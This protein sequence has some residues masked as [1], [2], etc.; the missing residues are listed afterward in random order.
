MSVRAR[1]SGRSCRERV[2]PVGGAPRAPR[3]GGLPPRSRARAICRR[4]L[5]AVFAAALAVL[6]AGT[7]LADPADGEL[8]LQGGDALG[9]GRV[10]VYHDGAWGAVCD[11]FW[12]IADARVV[13]RQLGY[14]GATTALRELSGPTDI[15]MW[16]DNMNC[17]GSEARLADCDGAGWGPHNPHHCSTVGEHAGVACTLS[18]SSAAVLIA[19][20]PVVVDEHTSATYEV[21]LTKLPSG[22]VTVAIGGTTG[23][24]VS[25]DKTSLTFTT[26]DWDEPQTVTVTAADDSDTA[27][28]TV[29]LTH[30]PTGGG[31]GSVSVPNLTVRVEDNDI[32][33]AKVEPDRVTIDEGDTEGDTAGDSYSFELT[34]E[35]TGTVT[36]TV[37]GTAGTDVTA[38]PATLTFTTSD[39]STAQTVTVTA[40]NDSDEEDDRVSLTH[41]AA[42]GGYGS[43]ALPGVTVLVRDRGPDVKVS[44]DRIGI[45]EGDTPGGTYTVVLTRRPTGPVT[46]TLGGTAG[47][48]VTV[49]PASLT[50]TTSD[51]ETA[52]TVS[53]SAAEDDDSDSDAAWITHTASGGGFGSASVAQVAVEVTDND[54]EIVTTARR[55]A[56]DEG[57]TAT[58]ELR[59][60]GGPATTVT[61]TLD[62]TSGS[63]VTVNPS[64]VAFQTATWFSPKPIRV[65]APQDADWDPETVTIAH[66]VSGTEADT[67]AIGDVSVTVSDD[68]VVQAWID[69]SGNMRLAEGGQ[70]TYRVQLK[71]APPAP[72]TVTM[73]APSKLSVNP[74]S[75]SFDS[76]NWSEWRT[77]TVL[78]LQDADAVDE[79][80]TVTH[81]ASD[82]SNSTRLGSVNVIVEDDDDPVTVIGTRPDGALWWAALTARSESDGTT[83]YIDYTG[84]SADTGALS[85]TVFTYGGAQRDIDALFVDGSGTLKL[86][87]DTGNGATLPNRLK[88]HVGSA[89]VTLESATRHAFYDTHSMMAVRDHVYAWS[90]G[91]HSVS[92]SDRDVVAVWLED[93]GT[94]GLPGR[95]SSVQAQ[96]KDGGAM[97]EWVAPP[98]VP[99]KPVTHYEYQQD[100][101]T[102]WTPTSGPGTSKE[103]TGLTN[104]ENYKFRLRAV[105][106]EGKGAASKPSAPVTP[107]PAGLTASFESVPASHDGSSA[108]TL[109]LAFSEA[110]FDGSESFNKN[111]AI[112][113]A[114]EVTGGT[115][116]G[117]RRVD[118]G[119]FDRWL[120]W[121]RPSGDGAVTVT[122]PATT[123]GCDAAGAICTPGGEALA[124][125]VTVSV[126]GPATPRV[127]IAAGTSPV[128]EGTAASFTLTRTGDT[129]GAL[130]VG[131]GV[132]EDG[133]VL[134]GTAPTEA[135]FAAGAATVSLTVAT[136]DDEVVEDAS[137][138][139]VT[140][141]SGTGYALDASASEA[142]VT[143]EEDDAAPALEV[144][145]VDGATLTLT[146]DEALDEGSE[147]GAAAFSVT[148][149]GA[150]RG[151]D[152]VSVSGS[153]VTLTLASAVASGETV[154]VS[155]TVPTGADASPL[156]DAAGNPAA[157]FSDEAV[158][159]DTATA[160]NEPTGLP[161]ITG[162]ARVGETLTASA[163]GIA[164]ADGLA[165]ATFAWQWIAND[166]TADTEITD[167]TAAE[168][169]LTSAEEGKT[170]MVR[171]TFTDDGGNE[172][173]LVSAATASVA[174][175]L[176][177]VSIAASSSSVTEGTA[178][179]F[180]LSRTGDATAALT[181]AVSVTEAGSVL[182]GTPPATATFAAGSAEVMLAVATDDDGEAEAD[183]RATAT[184]SA[185]TGYAVDADAASAGIDVYDN[186]EA[187]TQGP[188]VETLWT[189]TLTVQDVS[190]ALLGHVFGNNLSSD[191]WTEDGAQFRV[192]QLY[193][194]ALYDE[195]AFTLSAA[196]PDPGQ[197]TLHLDDL[198]VQLDGVSGNRFFYWTVDHP[199]WEA[200][201]TVAVKLTREDPDAAVDAGPGISVADAQVQE[202]E[203]A[204]LAFGVTLDEAQTSA[205]S[206]RYATADG[207]AKAGA[208]YEAVSGAL[209]FEA[210]ETAKTVSVAVLNDAVDE[211]SETLT[212]A[213]SAPFGATLADGEATGTI[214]NTGPIPQAWITRFGRTVA[215]QAVDAIGERLTGTNDSAGAHVVVGGVELGGSGTL[216]GML[217]GEEA[218]GPL[219]L[220]GLE[221][222]ARA[223]EGYGMSG[224]AL[225]LGSSF[226]L[227][228]G[229]EDGG[230]AWTAW[231]RL[232]TG[233][234]EGADDGLTLS[235]DVTTGFLGADMAQARW[236]AGLAVGLSEGE[237]SFDDGAGGGG[238]V[239]SSLTSV[240][241]YARL[242]LGDGVDLWGL[243]GAGSGDLRLAVGR[244]VTE[245]GLSMRMGALGLR[246]A[247]V[248]VTESGAAGDV[249]LA[250]T[251]DA[252]WVR[253]E[254]NAAE[255][256]TGGNLEAASGE[257]SRLRL[258]LEG[259]RAFAAGPG[260]TLTPTLELGLRLDGG[261]AET[262]TGV[263]AG[264]GLQ[265]ADSAR[266]LTVEGRVR[267]LLTHSDGAYEEWGASGSIRLDPGVSGRGL[268]LAIM[269]VWGTASGG[270]ERLWAAG[271][272]PG[273]APDEAFEAGAGLQAELGYGLRPPVGHGAFTPYAGFSMADNG[274]GRTWRIGTRWAAEPAFALALEASRGETDADP[275]TAA[276]IR[277]SLRW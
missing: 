151:V 23:T 176:P 180:T 261:D 129:A 143:V 240:F 12:G 225:L 168:Y 122:L 70:D 204:V 7:A 116:R 75:L 228:A 47:T 25:L 214:V 173:M 102:D 104:G 21:W 86:W 84:S 166:G 140:L 54:R 63:D 230:P 259:S 263:E 154:T 277:A 92:L 5:R 65:S 181:V 107:A 112:Q 253:T 189:S 226:R 60:K 158:T 45:F 272:A 202:A 207:S 43:T 178:A 167:A 194:F 265:Y 152:A 262:G 191:G 35:P 88:L 177:A 123:G 161:T 182:S 203:G 17:S 137:V 135:V 94:R 164:D 246:A 126:P 90:A 149:D 74:A 53:V 236:L 187:A 96:A 141:A 210:G 120:V 248:P 132:S 33:R 219:G 133:A 32:P 134:S 36:V 138:V 9:E 56:I 148:V 237:G 254:S 99:S 258:G 101:E 48:D 61:V 196:P 260:A 62:V 172:E 11:D 215:L 274:G 175:A 183:G 223:D 85:D 159:N 264:F 267:G 243:A 71:R 232:A 249:G 165:N 1:R 269:P 211:G 10:E 273:L 245:T 251:S 46:I 57:T 153:A 192:N 82:G 220:P 270:V 257:V 30:S 197:L 41:T 26:T 221:A 128:T 51:W 174:A 79:R 256:S 44:T 146:F 157:G 212:L 163:S 109:E 201:Q 73:G 19:P 80:Q 268:S 31:Y 40:A 98:E 106:S 87:V 13:C 52:Q 3:A 235:G 147:S 97:L 200:G 155:Y 233:G 244:E 55:L 241:P 208:D 83:G 81:T 239:E 39:W 217:P 2:S 205:V 170:V 27:D 224:R 242:G 160:N 195:L 38:D 125:A 145:S 59:A 222:R 266:G 131:L 29:T 14:P 77:V 275:T 124:E 216:A 8:R 218:E 4:A 49:N 89:S 22:D 171:V 271:P 255:S 78:A 127:S 115:V 193:Y 121:I 37:S 156:Q 139:T 34:G 103:V 162:T 76:T 95:P 190:G 114:L 16:L 206:V 64:Q 186:D 58:Y 234:F 72:V 42:G 188:A 68:D 100:G 213:L 250:L 118:P 18:A 111:R 252:L 238:T 15:P 179:S 50:F 93:P 117:R 227:G 67:F 91:A 142:T 231:G 276:T 6:W 199:G 108:F 136:E 20:R 28:D 150:S 69:Y 247:L 229:G 24:D 113:N 110:V 119:A 66:S 198:E 169:T 184:V 185:G 144:A 209:R 130:T 105:N